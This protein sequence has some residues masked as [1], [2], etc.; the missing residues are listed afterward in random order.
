MTIPY[1]RQVVDDDDVRAVCDVLRSDWLTTGPAVAKFEAAVGEF[2]GAKHAVAVSSGTAALHVAMLA[3]NIGPGDEVIVPAITFVATSNAALYCGARPVFADV[4]RRTLVVD[5][6]SVE[7][8]ITP[9]TKA[10]VG[11]DY[12]GHPCDWDSLRA[13]AQKHGLLLV[14]DACHALGAEDRGRKI[15]TLADMT[16]LSFHP[17]KHITTGEGGMVLTGDSALFDRVKRLRNHGI[18]TDQRQRAERGTFHYD[19]V[20]LGFNYRISDFA[21]ALGTSQLRKLPAWLARR[22]AI[23]RAYDEALSG[24]PLAPL[25]RAPHVQHAYHLYVV[26]TGPRRDS[27]FH[28][29]RADGIGVNVHYMPVY[30]HGYYRRT[31]GTAPGLCPVAEAA[32]GEVLSLPMFAGMT[33]AEVARVIDRVGRL[34][35]EG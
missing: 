18:D 1:G 31:L 9:R 5:P 27:L 7:A 21:C 14:D 29:L 19:M 12:A 6:A 26:R 15:G 16:I 10:I 13:I 35:R 3:A 8:A 11:V 20:E 2:V 25:G 17:V 33:D 30:L 34:S 23:A 24:G 4:D 32:Y 22:N 28:R